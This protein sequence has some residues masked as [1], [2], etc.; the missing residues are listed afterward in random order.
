MSVLRVLG[1]Q[2]SINVRKVLWTCEEIGIDYVQEDWGTG[3]ASTRTPEFLALNPNGLVPVIESDDGI[4]WESNTICRYLASRH[5]RDDL[6]PSSPWRRALVERWMD[7]QATELNSAWR[8]AFQGLVRK[9]AA[10]AAPSI[11]A[12]SA[13]DWNGKMEV[14]ENT[15]STGGPFVTGDHFTL[16]DIL[17]GLSVNRWLHT[18]IERPALSAVTAYFDRLK[19][20]PSFRRGG[21]DVLP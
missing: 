11:I 17:I 16:A 15:L 4:L 1:R 18:P 8:G 3:F 19:E 9:D 13:R 6:L 21:Y 12:A 10:Y 2:S 14:L 7:W 20:R 5:S